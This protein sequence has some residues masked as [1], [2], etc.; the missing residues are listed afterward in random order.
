[1]GQ[2]AWSAWL[3]GLGTP[4][5]GPLGLCQGAL[6]ALLTPGDLT[7]GHLVAAQGDGSSSWLRRGDPGT[8]YARAPPTRL[9]PRPLPVDERG[10]ETLQPVG[11]AQ[12]FS[13]A[14]SQAG[15]LLAPPSP[16][17]PELEPELPGVLEAQDQL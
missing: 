9:L 12:C 17:E 16:S 8:I 1:M 5:L 11:R 13:V 2:G 6:Q 15:N 14:T 4:V 10:K 7:R 3:G